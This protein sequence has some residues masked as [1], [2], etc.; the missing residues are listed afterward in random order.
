MFDF[1]FSNI[2]IVLSLGLFSKFV[3]ICLPL[4]ISTISMYERGMHNLRYYLFGCERCIGCRLCEF[5]CPAVALEV[6][7]G[8]S[9]Y[10]FRYTRLFEVTY[11]RCIYCGM[12]LLTIV[13]V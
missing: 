4:E 13:V 3:T 11:R 10:S 6:L 7:S 5:V 1:L 12:M 9:L 8:V 2:F